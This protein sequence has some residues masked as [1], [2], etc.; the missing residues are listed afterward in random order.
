MAP[1]RAESAALLRRLPAVERLLQSAALAPFP[2][3]LALRS[4]RAVVDE[5]RRKALSGEVDA[6]TFERLASE[7]AAAEAA[8]QRALAERRM[9]HARVCNATGIVLHTGLGR[10]PLCEAAKGA[11]LD[12][13]GYS[14]VEVDPATGVRD[15]RELAISALLREITGAEAALV[16]NNNAAA[17]T[18]ALGALCFEQEVVVSRGEL[19]EIGGGF[20]VPDVMKRAGCLMVEVGATNKTH[21]RDFE[22]AITARTKA[23]LKVH[24]SNFR[25]E[26]FA[27]VP[28]LAD[29]SALAHA[30][31]LFVIDDLG[32][33][34]LVDVPIRGLDG[35]PRVRQ[36][37]Q[38]GADVVCFSGDKLLGGPQCGVLLG[39]KQHVTAMR[40]H[41]LYRALRCDK[42]TLSALEATLRVYRDADPMEEIPALRMLSAR[43]DELRLRSEDLLALLPQGLGRVV[44]SESFAGSGANPAKPLPSFAVAIPGGDALANLLRA[45]HPIAVFARVHDGAVLLDARTLLL[46]DLPALAAI[47]RSALAPS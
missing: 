16:V 35:E 33:G 6:A 5:L 44:A 1:N 11:I 31:G 15:Q 43:E 21:L 32:S 3:G 24:P 36:S 45:A 2:R 17:T 27:G 4:A 40:A 23:F 22:G 42:L 14:V 30:R 26:G 19:V 25:I 46:E 7:P 13:A 9:R 29:L 18:L 34:L 47:V 20:R 8:A 38:A 39:K 10:A 41:P 37:L 28:P 12:A